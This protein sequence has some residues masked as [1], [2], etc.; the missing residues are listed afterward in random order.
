LFLELVGEDGKILRP[1]DIYEEF[2][3]SFTL[4]LMS[5]VSET[6]PPSP[7]YVWGGEKDSGSVSPF[8]NMGLLCLEM[9]YPCGCNITFIPAGCVGGAVQVVVPQPL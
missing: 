6:P 7:P 3:K 1:V 8:L 9:T 5:R 4:R 2:L